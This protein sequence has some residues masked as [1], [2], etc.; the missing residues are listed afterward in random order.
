MRHLHRMLAPT[1]AIALV[2]VVLNG[3]SR[4][5]FT[6]PVAAT[7][8]L[9]SPREPAPAPPSRL[10][11]PADTSSNLLGLPLP[12]PQ[13]TLLDWQILTAV[14][15]SPDVDQTVSGGRYTLQFYKGSLA[16]A[17]TVT[18]KAYDSNILDVQFGPH[19]TQFGTPV[20]LSIDF[21]GTAADPDSKL[22][23]A[24]E[25]VLWYLDETKNQWVEVPGTT[26][27][28]NKRFVVQLEHFSRYVLGGK[29]GWKHDPQREPAD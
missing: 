23:D 27:W 22:A 20:Q 8:P 12:L 24:S 25:P 3:C 21:S 18:I 1:L 14:L 11:V 13:I 2:A 7:A 17:D 5:S 15:V 26:D 19:G 4:A 28:K 29:A 6:A 16:K 10:S 9:A